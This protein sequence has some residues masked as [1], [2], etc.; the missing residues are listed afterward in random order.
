[1]SPVLRG[2]LL[3]LVLVNLVFVHITWEVGLFWL[4]PLYALTLAS[5]LLAGLQQRLSY[6]LLW[7]AGVLVIFALL[8]HDAT[9]T[10]VRFMLKDGLIL[11]AFCQVHLVNNLGRGQRPDLL[12]FNSFLIPLVT[13][14][15]SQDL[16]YSAVFVAYA[17][18]L[19]LALQLSCISRREAPEERVDLGPHELGHAIRSAV[20]RATILLG[21]TSIAFLVVP[22]DFNRE[23]LVGAHLRF[24]RTMSEVGFAEEVRLGSSSRITQSNRIVLR[25]HLREG[26]PAQVPV[27][28]RGATFIHYANGEWFAEN[29]PTAYWEVE[30][31]Q[32]VAKE[33]GSWTRNRMGWGPTLRVTVLDPLAS[34]LFVPLTARRVDLVPPFDPMLGAP[35]RDGTL[36]F[37]QLAHA[38]RP[39]IVYD[40]RLHAEHPIPGGKQRAPRD[41]TRPFVYVSRYDVPRAA[42]AFAEQALAGTA[43]ELPQAAIVAR[44]RDRLS[45]SFAYLLPGQ[46]GAARNLDD[47]FSGAAGGHCEYFATALAILLRMRNI[48]CR[49]VTG[50][51]AT[52][53]D[54]SGDVLLVRSRDA[55]AWLEVLD[56][57][58]GWY[59]VDATPAATASRA[60]VSPS[61]FRRMVSFASRLWASVTGFDANRRAAAIAWLRQLPHR[62]AGFVAAHPTAASLACALCLVLVYLIRRRRRRPL[63]PA[64]RGYLDA[65][66][67]AGLAPAAGETPRELVAR[68]RLAGISR[69]RLAELSAAAR[70]HE[71]VRYRLAESRETAKNRACVRAQP[72]SSP[73]SP[74]LR[75]RAPTSACPR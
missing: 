53:W 12:F 47:F 52:E 21:A 35:L 22:R 56:P 70:A 5:P 73:S 71:N 36:R 54:A 63:P 31:D 28:W 11:A 55:H 57:Q 13:C 9:N 58:A 67:R 18:L 20:T 60:A 45:E 37:V 62:T 61:L 32:W 2:S 29:R 30:T 50:F 27:H 48:P 64:I 10:G 65:A 1:M 15:F 34:R 43:G 75:S 49:L 51:L 74:C 41:P 44:L 16:I 14:F 33:P 59:T 38:G 3:L 17:L 19:L 39:S 7:N 4:G 25:I 40:V 23:G 42:R 72:P 68:A 24:Q 46:P 66:R 8:V 69:D 6:R 26:D